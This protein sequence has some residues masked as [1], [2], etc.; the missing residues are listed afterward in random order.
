MLPFFEYGR[1]ISRIFKNDIKPQ[2]NRIYFVSSF[3]NQTFFMVEVGISL[4]LFQ[5][6]EKAHE[7]AGHCF[8]SDS[9]F[10]IFGV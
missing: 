10:R 6:R 5:P 9:G 3:S 8:G 4:T 1:Q 2:K 7:K